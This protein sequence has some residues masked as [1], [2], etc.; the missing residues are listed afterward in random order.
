MKA[1]GI[2]LFLR[3]F[4]NNKRNKYYWC[5]EGLRSKKR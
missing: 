4:Y 3:L 1:E 5:Y 2:V